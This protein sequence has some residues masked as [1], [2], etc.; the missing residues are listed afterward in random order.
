MPDFLENVAVRIPEKWRVFGIALKIKPTVL[1]GFKQQFPEDQMRC[2]EAVFQQWID[3]QA[4]FP[5][6]ESLL[7][8][9]RTRLLDETSLASELS[10]RI[11][12][13]AL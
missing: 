13:A 8:I 9:L 5:R 6:W 3:N 1:D 12:T 2:F 10:Q 7:K 4:E 11:G